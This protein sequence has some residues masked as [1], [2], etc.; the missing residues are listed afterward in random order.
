MKIRPSTPNDDPEELL[1][2]W[3][4]K[5]ASPELMER[6]RSAMP[7]P[8][9]TDIQP[10]R[11]KGYRSYF[12]IASS[13]VAAVVVCLFLFNQQPISTE[14]SQQ[15]SVALSPSSTNIELEQTR[16][17]ISVKEIGIETAND[18]LPYR[19]IIGRWVDCSQVK[20]GGNPNEWVALTEGE[21]ITRIPMIIY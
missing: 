2:Q 1:A 3:E 20:I 17:W 4:P 6:L 12:Y 13:L 15:V 8:Q 18:G 10:S 5:Q 21:G 9:E 11:K 19:V 14:A 7:E 16:K